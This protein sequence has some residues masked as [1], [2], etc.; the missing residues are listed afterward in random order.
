MTIDKVKM[1]LQGHE[2]FPLREGWLTKGLM[3]VKKES[4]VFLDKNATDIFGIGSNMVKSLRYWMKVFGLT[5]E[6][7][8]GLT[9]LGTL[10]KKNDMYI[11]DVFT[12]WLLHSQIAKNI[13]N[14]TAWYM[15]FNRFNMD[16]FTKEQAETVLTREVTKYAAGQSFSVQSLKNDIDVI[17]NMY[18]K[19]RAYIDPE[20]KSTSPFTQLG[21][22]KKNDNRFVKSHPDRRGVPDDIVLYE[23]ALLFAETD[24]VSI[25]SL[26][27]G[28][29][30][31]AS[32]YQLPAMAINEILDKLDSLGYIRVNRTAG[33]DVI[34][35]VAD[36]SEKTV[37][38]NYYKNSKR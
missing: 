35:K 6:K 34:Y 8:K 32:I 26:I 16:E 13:E 3:T 31:I 22:I 15:F 5:D 4:D 20:E 12:V 36:F 25:E 2:K 23:L 24:S 30:S 38:E 14:A 17:L 18:G 29:K 9:E 28:E 10:I 37:I 7:E 27:S 33:L 21:L 1:R 19:N 11:E